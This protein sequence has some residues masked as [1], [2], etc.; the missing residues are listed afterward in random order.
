MCVYNADLFSAAAV[1]TEGDSAMGGGLR[2]V[3]GGLCSALSRVVEKK[4]P[5]LLDSLSEA[6]DNLASLLHRKQRFFKKLNN[7]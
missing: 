2:Q 5:G 3:T 7:R 6:V 4:I 1:S